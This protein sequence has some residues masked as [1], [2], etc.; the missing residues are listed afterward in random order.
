MIKHK[1]AYLKSSRLFK[2]QRN[3]AATDR[4]IFASR[5]YHTSASIGDLDYNIHKS[6]STYFS[7]AD[8]ARTDFCCN[9][10]SAVLLCRNPEV[11]ALG[12]VAA[13]FRRQID[14]FERYTLRTRILAWD[15]KW[16]YLQSVFLGSKGDLRATSIAKYVFKV[17]QGAVLCLVLIS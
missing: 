5:D 13:S 8:M 3:V 16:L 10:F 9:R 6:N 14:P 17:M 2:A 11:I 1:I 7:D 15:Q 4:D 12:G